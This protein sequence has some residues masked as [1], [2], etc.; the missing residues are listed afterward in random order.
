ML[1]LTIVYI[2]LSRPFAR[3]HSRS[4][5]GFDRPRFWPTCFARLAPSIPF[6][7]EP[8]MWKAVAA[9]T[10]ALRKARDGK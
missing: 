2:N 4:V 1:E 7:Q 8:Q 10:V 5:P 6:R 9:I 3:S